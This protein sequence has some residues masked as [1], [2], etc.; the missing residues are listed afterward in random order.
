MVDRYQD[1]WVRGKV[2]STGE[3]DCAH[4]YDVI[5][6]FLQRFQR[7]FTVLDIGANIGYFS[8]RIGEDFPDSIVVAIEGKPKFLSKL[9]DV[10]KQNALD[11]VIVIGRKLSVDD[12]DKLATL[13]HF[14]VVLGMSVIHHIYH[15][16]AEGLAAFLRLGDHVIL[17]LPNEAKYGLQR[18]AA[19]DVHGQLL[20]HGASHIH[21]GSSR[22]IVLFTPGTTKTSTTITR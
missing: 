1:E 8:F 2:V 20:G 14:D 4:R 11:N 22:P 12:I 19:I 7:P 6:S 10:A 17:E 21:P 3:R 9:H 5:K 15:D 18:Y 16:P 13:E